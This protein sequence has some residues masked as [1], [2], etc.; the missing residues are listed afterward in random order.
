MNFTLMKYF[1]KKNWII[2]AGLTAFMLF[3]FTLMILLMDIIADTLNQM[4]GLFGEVT[5]ENSLLFIASL[6]P[7]SAVLYPMIFFI[8]VIHKLMS[9]SIE[10][11]SLA[12]FLTAGITRKQ[13]I[14]TAGIFV[15]LC[16]VAL[17]LTI[18]VVCGLALLMWG[19]FNWLAWL[20]LNVN[21]LLLNLAVASI[22]F[23]FSSVFAAT[24]RGLA[25][26]IAVPL[27][28]FVFFMISDFVSVFE[29]FTIYG[30]INVER[31]AL[32][33]SNYWW[34]TML[35]YSALAIILSTISV[36]IYK[37]KQLSI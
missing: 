20:N 35:A 1:I 21:F 18:F 34:V 22:C 27:L 2:W 32:G 3:E 13:Y 11:T 24:K 10:T 37:R 29:Y 7:M 4:G 17:F 30:W 31:I 28:L 9:K 12:A 19:S 8:F 36:I 5:G 26:S 6:F 33:T 23:F 16:L 14:I 25:L 15:A